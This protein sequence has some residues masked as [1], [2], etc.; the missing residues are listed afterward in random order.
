MNEYYVSVDIEA[1]GP[2]P[3]DY[4]MLSL[5]SA[6]FS[7]DGTLLSI[8]QEN[9]LPLPGAK[10]DPETMN[11]WKTQPEAWK[12]L[13]LDRR[14]PSSVMSI[15]HEWLVGLAP[16]PIFVGYPASYDFCFVY[17]YLIHFTGH[18]PFGHQA[19][20]LKTYAMAALEKEFKK[21]HKSSMPKEW[22][23]NLETHT[24]EAVQDAIEQGKL[25]FN[26]RAHLA[27][28][29]ASNGPKI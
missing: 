3:G 4:S 2:I 9:L 10:E 19:L 5:G 22:F 13:L 16:K 28:K 1:D 29:E 24:H 21:T 11:W 14:E 7:D 17:W 8:F 27:K 26:I 6:A 15:Y 25:F 20:D 12:K 18:S 23:E